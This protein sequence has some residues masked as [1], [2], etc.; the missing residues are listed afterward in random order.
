MDLVRHETLRGITLD[1]LTAMIERS[2]D[3]G[4]L[5]IMK[6]AQTTRDAG[7]TPASVLAEHM[8]FMANVGSVADDD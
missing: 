5:I 7:K 2:L 3:S 1:N 8:I 4:A 6:S